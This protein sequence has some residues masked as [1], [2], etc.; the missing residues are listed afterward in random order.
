MPFCFFV[1]VCSDFIQIITKKTVC[2]CCSCMMPTCLNVCVCVCGQGPILS[3]AATDAKHLY[4][5]RWV[6]GSGK[7]AQIVKQEMREERT[8]LTLAQLLLHHT[9]YSRL[10]SIQISYRLFHWFIHTFI[11]PGLEDQ[12]TLAKYCSNNILAD[13]NSLCF[14]L[15]CIIQDVRSKDLASKW[16]CWFWCQFF[17]PYISLFFFAEGGNIRDTVHMFRLNIRT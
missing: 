12:R 8:L 17:H 2:L 6:S 1:S 5:K 4:R 13:V 14:S 7:T 10:A 16:L 3:L 11:S 9:L 15:L